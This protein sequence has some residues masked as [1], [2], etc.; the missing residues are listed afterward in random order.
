MPQKVA[1]LGIPLTKGAVLCLADRALPL[2]QDVIDRTYRITLKAIR[3]A[4]LQPGEPLIL[5]S[6]IQLRLTITIPLPKKR[7]LRFSKEHILPS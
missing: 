1:K 3:N 5:Q 2:T 7:P 6:S 4:L